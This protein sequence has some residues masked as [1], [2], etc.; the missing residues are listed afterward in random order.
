[1]NSM[2]LQA[3]W[4]AQRLAQEAVAGAGRR[5]DVAS[6]TG[7][8]ESTVSSDV[9]ERYHPAAF[10]LL[11]RLIDSPGTTGRAFA[12]RCLEAVELHEILNA[13]EEVLIE[14]GLF[15]VP[16]KYE[17]HSQEADAVLTGP[18]EWAVALQK[19]RDVT[20]ELAVIVLVLW[21]HFRVDL[22]QIYAERKR[23]A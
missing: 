14:R 10:D 17:S 19:H 6:A 7:R 5:K 2:R 23:A 13:S 18:V 8:S 9:T 1:M 11:L 4:H 16:A 15:L 3:R 12:E 21:R 20:S 22:R